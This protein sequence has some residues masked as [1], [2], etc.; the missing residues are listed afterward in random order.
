MDSDQPFFSIQETNNY[1]TRHYSTY[2]VCG[3]Y[4]VVPLRMNSRGRSQDGGGVGWRDYFLPYKLIKRSFECGTT[5]TK[6]VLNTGGGHQASRGSP[7]S[8]KDGRKYKR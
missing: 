5:F 4:Y 2:L 3:D 7:I 8:S 1:H 6:Q